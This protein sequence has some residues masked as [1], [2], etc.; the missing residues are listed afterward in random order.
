MT[1][2]VNTEV[3]PTD[4]VPVVEPAADA[5]SK[6]IA[7][8]AKQINDLRAEKESIV[9]AQKT[10]RD[11]AE[12]LKLEAEGN[13]KE[14]S[15][16]AEARVK[17]LE[18]SFKTKERDL[19]LSAAFAIIPDPFTRRGVIASCPAD[20]GVDEYAAK[21]RSEH[22]SLFTSLPFSQNGTPPQGMG[23][24][25]M[26]S[27]PTRAELDKMVNSGDPEKRKSALAYR[28]TFWA[29]HGKMPE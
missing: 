8:M 28:K 2:E 27:K 22:P 13:Y 29:T 7:A 25:N 1:E 11:E 19:S 3:V 4:T 23:S 26:T 12:R 20:M 5:E 14:L 16:R 10:A 9:N 6:R 15:A 24:S 21:I 17:E 18:E